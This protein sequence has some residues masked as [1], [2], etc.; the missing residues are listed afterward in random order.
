MPEFCNHSLRSKTITFMKLED[1]YCIQ[2]VG[3]FRPPGIDNL[4]FLTKGLPHGL[5]QYLQFG[6]GRIR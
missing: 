3:P 4:K 1:R 2:Q 6:T 5:F